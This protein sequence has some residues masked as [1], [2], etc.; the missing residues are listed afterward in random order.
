M[1]AAT[2]AVGPRTETSGAIRLFALIAAPVVGA[3]YLLLWI[4]AESGR[5]PVGGK[6]VVFALL[7]VAIGVS[8]WR[9]YFGLGLMVLV[10]L[11][12][13]IGVIWP[14][15]STTWPM[16]EAF[17]IVGFF[18]GVQRALTRWWV[19]L[20]AGVTATV[21]AAVD[22]VFPHYLWSTWP[23]VG[24]LFNP[25]SG[26]V[27]WIGSSTVFRNSE[28]YWADPRVLGV[29][30]WYVSFLVIVG[31]LAFAVAW[32]AGIAISLTGIERAGALMR[33]QWRRTDVELRLEQQRSAIAREVHDTLAHSL[34][35]VV[36]QA[37]GGVAVASADPERAAQSLRVIA[38]VSRSALVECRSLVERIHDPAADT[39]ADG[40]VA[41][42][43]TEL[44]DR[45]SG[46]GMHVDYRVL[47]DER[48]LPTPR[49]TA[50]FRIV[51]ESLTNALKHGGPDAEVTITADWRGDG[52]AL[53]I[54]SR[55]TAGSEALAGGAGIA[56]MR[57]RA[58]LAGGWLTAGHAD[59]GVF[60]VTA[61][62][63]TGPVEP[64][65]TEVE[66]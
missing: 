20:A 61:F 64:A 36:A 55:G 15:E 66:A 28:L 53:L 45:M 21:L 12:Q 65:R 14:A 11:A 48:E 6:L 25:S 41:T 19:V 27:S 2:L 44:V 52:L 13:L 29:L 17:A 58:R 50:Y 56:G 62:I 63:P 51:Q 38:D 30:A 26:W 32:G 59:D 9:P 33:T 42:D 49:R 1:T 43:L 47:G 46:L 31:V 24:A 23:S 16:Y 10:P 8:G 3:L 34:A 54:A 4:V 37:E 60:L 18:A 5:Y 7:A 22:M 35:V 57:E 40:P 39:G